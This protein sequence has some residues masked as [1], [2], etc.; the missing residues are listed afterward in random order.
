MRSIF[1]LIILV[2]INGCG[3][4]DYINSRKISS[5]PTYEE[6][7]KTSQ[8]N[9]SDLRIQRVV[10]YINLYRSNSQV[11]GDKT[12]PAASSI[13]WNKKLYQ[14]ADVHSRDMAKRD[15]FDHTGSDGLSSSER[16]ANV[17]YDWQTVAENISAGTD[18]PEQ[19][20][21]QWI[22]SPGHCHNIMKNA[23]TEI[24]MACKIDP[25]SEYKIYWTLVLAS[26]SS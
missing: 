4:S 26:P 13:R 25:L 12:Y 1:I 17:G 8:C 3:V 10:N 21:E 24:G 18:T 9:F 6:P 20:I 15:F 19:T 23:H 22:A 16:V 7:P 11:C 2:L 5:A 14:A